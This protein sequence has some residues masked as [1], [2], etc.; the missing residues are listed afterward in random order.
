[1]GLDGKQQC[2]QTHPARNSLE[3]RCWMEAELKAQGWSGLEWIE[4]VGLDDRP[5]GLLFG[6][7]PEDA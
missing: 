4:V 3:W 7:E 6:F 2:G 5:Y 1:M